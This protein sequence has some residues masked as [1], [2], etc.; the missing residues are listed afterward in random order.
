M[1]WDSWDGRLPL[2]SQQPPLLSQQ[3]PLV[4][5]ERPENTCGGYLHHE[6]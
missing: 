3:A 4:A 5:E 1:L 6:D 2:S